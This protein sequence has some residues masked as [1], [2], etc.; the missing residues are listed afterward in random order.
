MV[1]ILI[2]TKED[3]KS[4]TNEYVD[5]TLNID[6]LYKNIKKDVFHLN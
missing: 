1:E 6:E 3:C 5:N 4:I 2:F